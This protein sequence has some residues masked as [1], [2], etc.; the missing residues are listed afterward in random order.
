MGTTEGM[1]SEIPPGVFGHAPDVPQ[2]PFDLNK[3]RA[4]LTEARVTAQSRPL[5]IVYRD[6]DRAFAEAVRGYWTRA[7]ASVQ[8]VEVG[9]A[10]YEA[11]RVAGEF[12]YLITGPTR[13]AADQFL[14]PLQSDSVPNFYGQIDA[15]IAAQRREVDPEKR[16][17]ILRQIQMRI[18]SD[19][20][21]VPVFRPFYVTAF[22]KGVTGDVANT[23]YWLWY[24]ELMDL[25]K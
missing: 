17:A 9:S 8:L 20:P 18:S 21:M 10:P 4:L 2:F 3:A 22:R 11:R 25:P 16:K 6:T 12:D 14:L 15:L 5:Q 19:L 7:G 24:W 13:V 1:W 23:F